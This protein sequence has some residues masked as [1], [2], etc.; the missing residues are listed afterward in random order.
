[1]INKEKKD[2]RAGKDDE[3]ESKVG[4]LL[5]NNERKEGRNQ[6]NSYYLKDFN[7]NDLP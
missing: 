6:G 3:Q 2:R 5:F 7:G 4:L 1:L